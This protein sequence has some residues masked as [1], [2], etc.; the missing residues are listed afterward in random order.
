MLIASGLAFACFRFFRRSL[1]TSVPRPA[2]SPA[3]GPVRR[4]VRVRKPSP[5]TWRFRD[6]PS[7]FIPDFPFRFAEAPLSFS[8]FQSVA[9]R[10]SS[11]APLTA[12]A[13]RFRSTPKN[14]SKRVFRRCCGHRSRVN[15]L[16]FSLLV[17]TVSRR[18]LQCGFIVST[19]ESCASKVS[20]ASG[21]CMTYPQGVGFGVDNRLAALESCEIVAGPRRLNP[22]RAAPAASTA[23]R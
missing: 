17:T 18:N 10:P 23:R 15:Q 9:G 22:G 6:R 20:R 8:S 12:S 5:S 19:P 3:S 16:Q 4:L 11:F 1:R 14:F 2:H 13:V 7:T 21:I